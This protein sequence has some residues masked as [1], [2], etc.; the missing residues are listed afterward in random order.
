MTSTA[1]DVR[2]AAAKLEEQLRNLPKVSLHDHLDGSL[3]PETLIELAA[4]IGHELPSQDSEELAERFRQ[5]ANSGSLE[6]YLEAFAHTTAVMQ[7][8][9]NLR[10]V[11]KEYVEDLA[12]DGIIYSEVR[13][14]PEQHQEQGLSLDEAVEA[15]QEGLNQGMETVAEQDGVIVV[16]QLVSAM[17]QSDRADEIVE[18]ALRHRDKGVVGFDI[19]GPE[20]GFP[21]SRFADAFT[22]LATEMFPTTVHAGEGDGIESVRDAL[23]SGRAQRLGHGVRVAEDISVIEGDVDSEAGEEVFQVE[24]GPV[25]RWVRDRQIH[26]EVSPTSN[27]QTGA[28]AGFAQ[29]QPPELSDHPFDMLYQLGF[30]VGVNTDNRLVSGVTLSGE[31]ALIASTFDYGL[32][33]LAD[34]QVNAL[35]SSF[36][37]HEEREALA[38]M[39]LEAWQ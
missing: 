11:A 37:G 36:L 17:R 15:V 1:A 31:L 8:P 38:G 24:L 22:R 19:A 39:I 5:N 12:A 32:G 21:P 18:V 25:A 16:G 7:T 6:K 23:V 3:R 29:G 34:F 20:A 2:T 27:V 28:I 14:A 33:E 9:Q 4:E 13:W 30:N 10:R 35:E 26:L